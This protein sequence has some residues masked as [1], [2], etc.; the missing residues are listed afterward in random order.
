MNKICL[1]CLL[2]FCLFAWAGEKQ[3]ESRPDGV[4]VLKW[5]TATEKDV[6]GYNLFRSQTQEG[7]FE[8]INHK[9]IKGSGTSTDSHAYKYT[10]K[11]L[12]LG[13]TYYYRLQEVTTSG[14]TKFIGDTIR[15]TVKKRMADI[16]DEE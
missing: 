11:Y 5:S 6:Y 2:F 10:D 1:L 16:H 12:K 8:K 3:V 4:V 7:K 13:K 15:I 9:V 14:Q